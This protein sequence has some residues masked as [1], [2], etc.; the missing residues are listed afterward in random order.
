[1]KNAVSVIVSPD[2]KIRYNRS[3]NPGLA[4]GGSGDVLTGII[5][6]F[7][8][9]GLSPFDAASA[10]AFL[11]GSTAETALSVLAERALT[12]IDIIDLIS[13]DLNS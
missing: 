13:S 7:L 4:K 12:A 5:T 10:G 11:L 3:G 6:A 2:G 1:M 9:N 8:A